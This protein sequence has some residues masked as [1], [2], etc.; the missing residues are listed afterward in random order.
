MSVKTYGRIAL[1]GGSS[2]ALDEYDADNLNEGD[3]CLTVLS[4]GEYYFHRLNATSGAAENSPDV[5]KPD[6]GGGTSPYTGDKRWLLIELGNIASIIHGVS[7]KTTPVDAD[8]IGLIDSAALWVLKKLTWANLK[9]TLKTYFDTLY[10]K[11]IHPNHSGEVTSVA[12]GAQ[13]I[14]NKA[15]T[16][17]KMAD[18]ATAS[19][20][21]RNT[22][23]IGAPEVL[24]KATAQSLLNVEDNADVTDAVNVGSSIHGVVNKATPVDADKVPSIDTEDS[25]TLKTSTWTNIKAF[26]KT[27]FDGIYTVAA[28]TITDNRLVRG[29]GGSRGVQESPI[30]ISD[31][32]VITG[33]SY[34]T[35][36]YNASRSFRQKAYGLDIDNGAA[37]ANH[38]TA[39]NRYTIETPNGMEIDI[40][41]VGYKAVSETEI[42]LNTAGNWDSAGQTA[43]YQ[44]A[45]N[46]AG[47]DFYV[48]AEEP[49]SDTVPAF[50][51]SANSTN[52]D[53]N[54]PAGNARTTSNTRK[55]GGFHCLCIAVGDIVNHA[56]CDYA[57]GDIL[58]LS[59]WDLDNRPESSPE[60]MVHS[61]EHS[62]T[63]ADN[64]AIIIMGAN[65]WV[66]IYL[67]SGTGGSTASVNGGTIS[68]TRDWMDFVD[69]FGAVKKQLLD[70]SE[71]QLIAAG[72]NEETNINGSAD[73]VTTGGHSDIAGRRMISNIGCEDC[74]GVL[75]QWLKDQ[76]YRL[77]GADFA[78][79]KTWA[80]YDLPG[81]KGSLYRQANYGDI[82][83]FAGGGWSAGTN[84]GSR[85]RDAHRSRW[86]AASALG[87]RG[88]SRK[89]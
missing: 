56:L 72:S 43:N 55:V 33:I 32:G 57:Q 60:G 64:E 28:S 34:M 37:Q 63:N 68:D 20:L 22:A 31:A 67:A 27:Y 49:A 58:F 13:T 66:D 70:D 50:I 14:T 23:G 9:A 81:S 62:M 69:D 8:E 29:D 40:G 59:V 3:R 12:D 26:L 74:A 24:S 51:L 11:Y 39:A 85:C 2:G 78:A 18:M 71:F 73:P 87:G 52:P 45:A 15:V 5:I 38:N 42:S 76:S 41:G 48:Y 61:I 75:Y 77:D 82:K 44:I 65:I 80:W 53:G 30:S 47:K 4:T 1:I 19:L 54:T 89:L 46:R 83:L 84:C 17:A 16:L 21:G 10:N 79:A 25:N 88:R 86:D 36:Y 6:S 35:T 7:A